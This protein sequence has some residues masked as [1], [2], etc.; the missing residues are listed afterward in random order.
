M[1]GFDVSRVVE[2][3]LDFAGLYYLQL[4]LMNSAAQN[5]LGAKR[6]LKNISNLKMS[7]FWF[8]FLLS[9]VTSVRYYYKSVILFLQCD[10]LNNN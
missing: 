5:E 6:C 2:G 1:K 10:N 8:F 9:V 4:L 7:V 3:S